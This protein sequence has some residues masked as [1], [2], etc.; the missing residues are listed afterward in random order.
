MN[1]TMGAIFVVVTMLVIKQI[2]ALKKEWNKSEQTN[3]KSEFDFSRYDDKINEIGINAM[4]AVEN[5][6]VKKQLLLNNA[7]K[8]DS[9]KVLDQYISFINNSM[10]Y[11]YLISIGDQKYN[12]ED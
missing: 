12:G 3:I 8:R 11:K 9:N 10:L 1:L 7:Q 4:G 2:L 5:G 6:E